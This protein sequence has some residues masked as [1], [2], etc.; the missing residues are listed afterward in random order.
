M[1]GEDGSP[2]LFPQIVRKTRNGAKANWIPR[3]ASDVDNVLTHQVAV[4]V[5]NRWHLIS[6]TL[7]DD[8]HLRTELRNQVCYLSMA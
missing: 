6:W 8:A 3:S 5:R 2:I 7:H 4:M 1:K